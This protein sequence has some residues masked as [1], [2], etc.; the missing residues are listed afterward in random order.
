MRTVADG[1]HIDQFIPRDL[2]GM[3]YRNPHPENKYRVVDGKD[4]YGFS[5]KGLVLYL[6]LWALKGSSFKSVDAY[7]HTC[8]PSGT[9]KFWTPTGWDLAGGD[10]MITIG[11]IGTSIKTLEFWIDPETTTQS[12]L[13]E[14]DNVGVT[15]AGGTMLYGSWDD[16]FIDGVNTDT[17]TAAFHQVT[18]TSTANVDMSAFRFGLV[19]V[20]NLD[21]RVG[22]I[23]A[24]TT[25]KVLADALRNYNMTAWR[26]Q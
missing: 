24:Y 21:G 10:E 23:R 20:T 25:Q 2:R 19:N 9:T 6:P 14:I 3:F 11:N 26:Y 13:E 15:V 17:I 5:T 8:T 4:P 7:K 18:L 22:E 12:I 16:C 1:Q